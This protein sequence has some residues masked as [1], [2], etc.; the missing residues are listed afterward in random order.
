[1]PENRQYIEQPYFS[2][3]TPSYNREKLL[4]RLYKSLCEQQFSDMEWVVID[5]GS[6]DGTKRMIEGLQAHSPFPIIY[7]YQSN[8]GKN[9][10]INHALKVATG[11]FFV[12]IDSDDYFLPRSLEKY[13]AIWEG[14]SPEEQATLGGMVADCVHTDG[15]IVG[16]P[17]PEDKIVTNAIKLRSQ[18]KVRGD[19]LYLYKL[20]VIK[21][22]PTPEFDGESYMHPTVRHRR[23]AQD[24][25]LLATTFAGRVKDYQVDGLSADI[26]G[27]IPK[28]LQNP[29]GYRL[30]AREAVDFGAKENLLEI[31][32][33]CINYSR[34]SLHCGDGF[35]AQ[36]R[37]IDRKGVF[38]C[39]FLFG[40]LRY[41]KD[42]IV[43]PSAVQ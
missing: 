31:W 36:I 20:G 42:R 1:M 5:D 25:S 40:L 30:H 4:Y 38:L 14:L 17:F 6:T 22:R 24:Y 26:P 10:A 32:K 8:G 13:K 2:I 37:S 3:V 21:D 43:Y 16:R 29:Q 7:R 11:Y 41:C 27:Q 39:S 15:R 12:D 28:S 19:K 34:F 33:E 23:I 35:G 18:L 9:R